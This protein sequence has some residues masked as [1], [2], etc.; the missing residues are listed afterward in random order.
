VALVLLQPDLGTALVFGAIALGVLVVA[1]V[2]LRVLALVT[3]VGGVGAVVAVRAGIL[4]DYQLARLAA[5]ADP[6]LDPQ[7]VGYSTAQA[8]AAIG[9]GGLSGTGLFAGP[10]TASGAVPEQ[11]TDFIVTVAGEELGFLG[12]AFLV[13]LLGV[14]VWRGLRIA[15]RSADLFGCLA[16]TGV[17]AWLAMQSFQ[18]LGMALGIMPV[19]GIPLPFVSYGGS[20]AFACLAATGLLLNIHRARS[21]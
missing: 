9:A 14:V 1:G 13:L 19:T 16:A 12:C 20:S 4:R 11:Q 10:R 6:T 8:R 2:R 3:A 7:G 15:A 18:N 17:V 5:F 21:R